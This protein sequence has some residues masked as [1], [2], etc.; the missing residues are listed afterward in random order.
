MEHILK[1]KQITNIDNAEDGGEAL[2]KME[3][4]KYNLVLMDI[5][6]PVIDG[7]TVVEKYKKNKSD[8]ETFIVA[9]TAGISDD[10]KQRCFNA[11]MDAFLS[12]PVDIESFD[13]V[14]KLMLKKN[15]I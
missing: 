8:D 5:K 13:K 15:K 2:Y 7:I 3:N 1:F 12:K 11:K 6:I 10:I 14:I 9:V 4:N